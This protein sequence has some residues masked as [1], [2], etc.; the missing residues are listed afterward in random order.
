MLQVTQFVLLSL[1]LRYVGAESIGLAAG[2]TAASGIVTAILDGGLA[3]Y[4]VPLK[5]VSEDIW[6]K[7][8]GQQLLLGITTG[9]LLCV[10][11]WVAGWFTQANLFTS[12]FAQTEINYVYYGLGLSLPFVALSR[13]RL[14]LM[15]REFEAGA[16]A[17]V[18]WVGLLSRYGLATAFVMISGESTSL[19][20]ASAIAF[21]LE[22]SF[23]WAAFPAVRKTVYS[24]SG[25]H[26]PDIVRVRW[27]AGLE[28]VAAALRQN[29]DVLILGLVLSREV[30]GAYVYVS[31]L[32]FQLRDAVLSPLSSISM[33]GF[34][35]RGTTLDGDSTAKPDVGTAYLLQVQI[36][37]A[38]LAPGILLASV[39]LAWLLPLVRPHVG[40]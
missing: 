37:G 14:Q 13:L 9:L 5:E 22:H 21:G 27:Q 23:A 28:T 20:F 11:A 36:L 32:L 35:V 12:D 6:R 39:T 30:L 17:G 38:F 25:F 4:L 10:G 29:S 34:A 2:F 1:W 33:L 18:R 3:A 8:C 26:A 24:V 16:L 7:L 40:P 15:F 31:R 19:L